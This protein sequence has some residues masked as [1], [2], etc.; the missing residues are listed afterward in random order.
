MAEGLLG[1]AMLETVGTIGHE[2]AEIAFG[3]ID[4]M[5][6]VTFTGK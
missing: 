3:K 6:R 4:F 5:P 2:A 1:G